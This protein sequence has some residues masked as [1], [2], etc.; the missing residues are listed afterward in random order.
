MRKVE[1]SVAL[2]KRLLPSVSVGA[3]DSWGL[4]IK[5]REIIFPIERNKPVTSKIPNW[6]KSNQ[7]ATNLTS[8]VEESNSGVP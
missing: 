8:V 7:L 6:Q 4:A 3:K 1:T 5:F 2:N